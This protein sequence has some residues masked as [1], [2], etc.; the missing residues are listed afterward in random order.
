MARR[1]LYIDGAGTYRTGQLR[2]ASCDLLFAAC[3]VVDRCSELATGGGVQPL[4]VT[5]YGTII[6]VVREQPNYTRALGKSWRRWNQAEAWVGRMLYATKILDNPQL[7]DQTYHDSLRLPP[8]AFGSGMT[9][10]FF[11]A[12]K[13]RLRLLLSDA[14]QKELDSLRLGC[15]AYLESRVLRK[16]VFEGVYRLEP[17]PSAC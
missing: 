7:V 14:V 2:D 10:G 11:E 3:R 6:G 4:P 1:E 15:Y 9:T 13:E 16:T 5:K 17:R 8:R 12:T